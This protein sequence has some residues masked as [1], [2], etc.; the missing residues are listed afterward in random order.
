MK[1]FVVYILLLMP[2][3]ALGQLFPKL[4]DFKGNIKHVTE[5]RYGKELNTIKRDSGV[6]KP[7]VFSG[8]QFD[9][10]F[11]N[12]KLAQRTVKMN[13]KIN[14]DYLYQFEEI[15]NRRIEREVTQENLSGQNGDYVEYENFINSAGQVEKVNFWSF[16]SKEN[17][18]ELYMVEMNTEY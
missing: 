2:V 5:R 18:R 8:W 9:Y 3:L 12:A 13:G 11:E 7:K 4:P 14:A 6:F 1:K 15:G 16:N 17:K 10:Q